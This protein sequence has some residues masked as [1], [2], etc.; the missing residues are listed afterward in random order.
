MAVAMILPGTDQGMIV[1]APGENPFGRERGDD[2][3]NVGVQRLRE[4]TLSC[5]RVH[6]DGWRDC[7]FERKRVVSHLGSADTQS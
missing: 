2:V 3:R 4:S 5:E 7:A 6:P 1:I